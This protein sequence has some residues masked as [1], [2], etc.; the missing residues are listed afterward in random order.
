VDNRRERKDKGDYE[1]KG[2]EVGPKMGGMRLPPKMLLAQA[3]LDGYV[4]AIR[5]QNLLMT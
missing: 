2:R 1:R 5:G 3:S 4:L